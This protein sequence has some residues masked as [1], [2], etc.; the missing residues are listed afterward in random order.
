MQLLS[1][2]APHIA[3]A[4]A[5]VSALAAIGFA[6]QKRRSQKRVKA[7][8][9][10]QVADGPIRR[11]LALKTSYGDTNELVAE[12][13]RV[14]D[15]L[16][17]EIIQSKT[18]IPSQQDFNMV[19]GIAAGIIGA[20][21]SGGDVEIPPAAVPWDDG[22][23]PNPL[24]PNP[25]EPMPWTDSPYIPRDPSPWDEPSDSGPF[26][27][28]PDT[29]PDTNGQ[30]VDEVVREI[31]GQLCEYHKERGLGAVMLAYIEPVPEKNFKGGILDIRYDPPSSA[32]QTHF[33]RIE[34]YLSDFGDFVSRRSAGLESGNPDDIERFRQ[35]MNRACG[36]FHDALP[37]INSVVDFRRDSGIDDH[38]VSEFQIYKDLATSNVSAKRTQQR[39]KNHRRL[40][41][42]DSALDAAEHLPVGF[43]C[44]VGLTALF[45]GTVLTMRVRLN[46]ELRAKKRS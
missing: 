9:R 29:G 37:M 22:M 25:Y 21:A 11:S 19:V 46:S 43:G 3:G 36:E 27:G 10:Y 35:F 7:D 24:G 4:A 42:T 28:Q 1:E 31:R 32:V 34:R 30:A 8:L 41:I 13:R 45:Y 2:F 5:G 14:A 39:L 40:A 20:V 23:D 38:I 26:G 16:Q 6:L 33:S 15:G 18:G 17:D 44:L 12:L